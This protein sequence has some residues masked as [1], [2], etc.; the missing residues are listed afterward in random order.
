MKTKHVLLKV[1]AD[2]LHDEAN[3]NLEPALPYACMLQLTRG[4][5]K[6]GSN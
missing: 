3:E 2:Q 1:H 5:D 4:D 6:M